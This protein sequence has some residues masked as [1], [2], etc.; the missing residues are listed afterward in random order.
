METK[1]TIKLNQPTELPSEGLTTVQVKPWKN[2]VI[3]F[4]MQDSYNKLF[5][6]GGLY[7]TWTAASL[8]PIQASGRITNIQ[9]QNIE[10]NLS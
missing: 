5:L 8:S 2:H 1:T 10:D 4:L 9:E 7:Q 6:P 3:N